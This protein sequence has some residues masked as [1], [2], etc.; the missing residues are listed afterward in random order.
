MRPA[1]TLLLAIVVSA[2]ALAACSPGDE[3][4]GA[5]SVASTTGNGRMMPIAPPAAPPPVSTTATQ[6]FPGASDCSRDVGAELNAFVRSVAD[7]STITFAPNGC[8][9]VDGTVELVDRQ[10][11]V[12]DGR[13][14]RFTAQS[15]TNRRGPHWEI[16]RG[17]NLVFRDLIVEGAS[18]AGGP[19]T[20]DKER[21]GETGINFAGTVGVTIE[22][23]TIEKVFGDFLYF[24]PDRRNH[25]SWA[26]RV[27][28]TDSK[29][30]G[31]S[32]QGVALT[33]VADARFEGNTIDGVGRSVFDIEPN[34][35]NGGARR[36]LIAANT[37]KR[38]QNT[39]LPIAG[40]GRISDIELRGNT[41]VGQP[42]RVAARALSVI[43]QAGRR[44]RIAVVD[45]VSSGTAGNA[46]VT[47]QD[48]DWLLVRGNVQAFEADKREPA[49]VA[50]RTCG[51]TVT[52]N[53]F[54]GSALVLKR[55][56]RQSEKAQKGTGIAC[57]IRSLEGSVKVPPVT[58][59]P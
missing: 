18:Q 11:L 43:T 26:R 41:L 31:S 4:K 51:V 53:R 21:G 13:G 6:E 3:G 55:S 40:R 8:Y 24:G 25:R 16:Q 59:T 20:Y 39:L 57:T 15:S 9:R 36:V 46:A 48:T 5:T 28:V 1:R 56:S 49:V 33:G 12:F 7:G 14:A 54:Q 10:R 22:R 19:G 35:A 50:E 47:I 44:A 30:L 32:R 2:T 37:V 34:G 45:N 23:V 27:A 29:L 58:S 17:S 52:G 38:W 42:L